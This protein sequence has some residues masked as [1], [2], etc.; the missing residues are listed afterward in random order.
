[1]SDSGLPNSLQGKT[2]A[3]LR[4]FFEKGEELIRDLILEN[5]KLKSQ[6]N[7]PLP[8]EV[9]ASDPN[10]IR[11]LV[12]R[13]SSLESE[14]EEIRR[15]AGAVEEESGGYRERLDALENEHYDLA[16]RHVA[17]VQFQTC[18]SIE[19]VLRASTEILLNFVGIGTFCVYLADEERQIFFPVMRE[20]GNVG[21]VSEEKIAEVR[22]R[23]PAF[24]TGEA[25]RLGDSL[26]PWI[27]GELMTLP[28]YA[29]SR[30]LGA[31][32]IQGFLAQKSEFMPADLELVSLVSEHAGIGV[33]N[34]W[35]RAH[36]DDAPMARGAIEDLVRA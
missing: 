30:L 19:E 10:V 17:A 28:L 4:E 15:I 35:L 27:E 3:F 21:E 8:E 14:I 16:C 9:D 36:A 12:G 25:W 26:D 24:A 6:L 32:R 20:G 11:S 33:E 18:E 31:V 13:I 29:G 7:A 1:M 2:D 34:A 5:D 23:V 22:E